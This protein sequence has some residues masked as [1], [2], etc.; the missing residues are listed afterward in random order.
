[1]Y[2]SVSGTSSLLLCP[3]CQKETETLAHLLQCRS[4]STSL[5]RLDGLD[6]LK[7]STA[8]KCNNDYQ[9]NAIIIWAIR[10]WLQHNYSPDLDDL[11]EDPEMDV[12][13]SED[14]EYNFVRSHNIRAALTAQDHIG[15]THF[16]RGFVAPQWAKLHTQWT[17]P[18]LYA[19]T[20]SQQI[21]ALKCTKGIN[22][23]LVHVI[24]S[25]H[26]FVKFMWQA[27]NAVL[28]S[29]DPSVDVIAHA[30]MDA[31]IQTMYERKF[32]LPAE[33]QDWLCHPVE[34]ILARQP[35]MRLR[36]LT[37][38]HKALTFPPKPRSP[39]QSTASKPPKPHL[40]AYR[41]FRSVFAL[42]D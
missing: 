12:D 27:R 8:S 2:Q 38:A 7:E 10:F 26:A 37:L 31:A 1:M 35:Y 40:P 21:A 33:S 34:E 24:K 20:C 5:A 17:F 14:T 41:D 19:R 42:P 22:R 6:I 25:V 3:C 28:H 23:R 39:R 36:W 11:L 16:F 18:D 13:F 32:E 9:G 29:G 30:D 15:W 4:A